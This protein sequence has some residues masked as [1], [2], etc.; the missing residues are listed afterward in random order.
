MPQSGADLQLV[1]PRPDLLRRK[2]CAAGPATSVCG[3]GR[4]YQSS[5]RGRLA[6]IRRH[7]D[8]EEIARVSIIAYSSFGRLAVST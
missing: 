2:L 1:R 3:L 4:R 8:D 6:H 7:L 5:R